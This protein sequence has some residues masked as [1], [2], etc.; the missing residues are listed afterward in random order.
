MHLQLDSLLQRGVYQASGPLANL[1][2]SMTKSIRRQKHELAF[3]FLKFQILETEWI[4]QLLQDM[5]TIFL[6]VK[7]CSQLYFT[8]NQQL[9]TKLSDFVVESV[10]LLLLVRPLCVLEKNDSEV[11]KVDSFGKVFSAFTCDLSISFQFTDFK[12]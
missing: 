1:R 8:F 2:V 6:A 3:R 7:S 9:E 12:P 4:L 11:T 5:E 10:K